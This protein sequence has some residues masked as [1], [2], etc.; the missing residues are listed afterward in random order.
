MPNLFSSHS[1]LAQLEIE[2][3]RNAA[4]GRN[5]MDFQPCR[6]IMRMNYHKN[7]MKPG[8]QGATTNG[9][10]TALSASPMPLQTNARTRLSALREDLRQRRKF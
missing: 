8:A 6:S 4:S 1:R 3:D 10:R 2:P 7:G 9:A 5:W